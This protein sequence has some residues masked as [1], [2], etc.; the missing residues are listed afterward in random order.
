MQI[1]EL[2]SYNNSQFENL[3]HLMTEL[4]DRVVL[5]TSDLDNVLADAN[6]HLYVIVDADKIIGCA[7][8]CYFHS[9]TGAKASVED[10]VVS[11]EYRGQHFGRQL[12][13]HLIDEAKKY[14]NAKNCSVELHLTSNPKRVVANKLYQALGFV[15]KETNCYRMRVES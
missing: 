11:T 12:V 4:S 5:T 2:R 9:P 13:E 10:V 14:A 8:L 3:K 1:T 15:R 6:A 7:T